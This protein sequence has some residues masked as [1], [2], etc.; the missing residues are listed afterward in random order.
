MADMFAHLY[1]TAAPASHPQRPADMFE[2]LYDT[3]PGAT[4]RTAV[5][6]RKVEIATGPDGKPKRENPLRTIADAI[7]SVPAFGAAAID[8]F[9][10]LPIFGE[11][12]QR[13]FDDE[14]RAAGYVRDRGALKHAFEIL[15]TKGPG[16]VTDYFDAFGTASTLRHHPGKPLPPAW[17]QATGEFGEQWVNPANALTGR[18]IGA[19]ASQAARGVRVARA[20]SP[21]LHDSL[22]ALEG[23]GADVAR[24]FQLVSAAA[25]AAAARA[26]GT[27]A[28]AATKIP[29]IGPSLAAGRS[30]FSRYAALRQRGGTPFV[31]AGLAVQA[32]PLRAHSEVL[33]AT[34]TRWGGLTRAQKIE[35][36]KLSHADANPGGTPYA[37]DPNVPEPIRGPSLTERAAAVRGD[38]QHDDAV[39]EALSIRI[40]DEGELYDSSRFFPMRRYGARPVY[41]EPTLDAMAGESPEQALTRAARRGRG[42]FSAAVTK[43]G[44][45]RYP[46]ILEPGVESNLHPDFDPAHQY[47]QHRLETRTAIYNEQA[48]RGLESVQGVDARGIPLTY[49]RSDGQ[50]LPQMARMPSNYVVNRGQGDTL[51]LGA[52]EEGRKA[53]ARYIDAATGLRARALARQDPDVVAA[54]AARGV[55]TS[56]LG[57]RNV[58]ARALGPY[59][60]KSRQ[61][62]QALT[63]IEKSTVRAQRVGEKITAQHSAEVARVAAGLDAGQRSVLLGS[64]ILGE[65]LRANRTVMDALASDVPAQRDAAKEVLADLRRAQAEPPH[66]PAAPPM[67]KAEQ[68]K[69]AYTGAESIHAGE[70]EAQRPYWEALA[71]VGGKIK[72]DLVW[73]TA[74][75]RWVLAGEFAEIPR[76]LLAPA[77][78]VPKAMGSGRAAG[79]VDQIT[80]IVR[81]THPEITEDDVR[82]FF[83]EHP[84]APRRADFIADARARVAQ[85]VLARNAQSGSKSVEQLRDELRAA[86]AQVDRAEGATRGAQAASG[87]LASAVRKASEQNELAANRMGETA[88]SLRQGAAKVDLGPALAPFRTLKAKQA[89]EY[90]RVRQQLE[91]ARSDSDLQ[92]IW[93]QTFARH[94]AEVRPSV[95]RTVEARAPEGYVREADLGLGSPSG[96]DMALDESFAD[97][98]KAG[99]GDRAT[100]GNPEANAFW[101]T[102]QT[103]NRLSRAGIVVF[104]F[105]HG[106][107]NLGM[108][109]LAGDATRSIRGDVPTLARILSGRYTP[110]PEV[111][112]RAVK[113]G[114]VTSSP[115]RAFAGTRDAHALTTDAGELTDEVATRFGRSAPQSGSPEV[116]GKLGPI[117]RAVKPFVRLGIEA[118]RRVYEPMNRWLFG[119]VEQGYAVDMFER[120][121]N[122]GMSDGEAA[123]KVRNMF[124]KHGDLSAGERAAHLNHLFYFYPWMKTVVPYWTQKGV[125]DPKW[126]QAPVRAIQVN[127]EQQGYDDPAAPFT[128]TAGR[129][130]DGSVRRLVVPI[131]QRVLAPIADAARI[132]FDVAHGDFQGAREDASAPVGYIT[133]HANV[134]AGGLLDAVQAAA[135]GGRSH[136]PPWNLFATNPDDPGWKQGLEIANKVAGRIAAPLS[137]VERAPAGGPLANIPAYLTGTFAYDAKSEQ[138]KK[139]EHLVRAEFAG[140]IHAARAANNDALLHRLLDLREQ[141]VREAVT[142]AFGTATSQSQRRGDMFEHLYAAPPAPTPVAHDMFSHL[143]SFPHSP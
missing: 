49:T 129:N 58:V 4:R 109:Y 11:A 76:A 34:Q 111:L 43:T 24:P 51:A 71:Q 136:V 105:V 102:M 87:S 93:K 83:R 45:K 59:L 138:R 85:E 36:Q 38:L 42:A 33:A 75:K 53:G 37:R 88:S 1:G 40:R 25:K 94:A 110:K 143:Y 6:A 13:R 132:P 139:V 91:K 57:T 48:R 46:T 125:L 112:A 118:D 97:F 14:Q 142:R 106:V 7:A 39:Q 70:T 124:G 89:A 17:L 54:A 56:L 69:A 113:S 80:A 122:A 50:V 107:N 73:D 134:F 135:N 66:E 127:N 21:V 103:L 47:M 8:D 121:T 98:I 100:L 20:A 10:G 130:A 92:A 108:A 28:G 19:L 61:A 72:P 18:G 141:R 29:G 23:A 90:D 35:V 126:W 9:Q 128:A 68:T 140:P 116:Q 52:G 104:P 78:D 12:D 26:G 65:G 5:P 3:R 55:S 99:E 95:E 62:G 117:A 133:G 41:A 31:G 96:Q 22:T 114:A 15:R 67:S 44:S 16:A 27:V 123:I 131:P 30:F 64:G 79:N 84:R 2:H 77:R 115:V 120:F 74:K 137:A 119:T 86:L 101:H 63:G 81:N 60:A 32:A 82:A